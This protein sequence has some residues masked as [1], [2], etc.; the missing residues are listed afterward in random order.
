MNSRL[1][2]TIA[3]IGINHGGDYDKLLRM[4]KSSKDSGCIAVKFQYRSEK[5]FGKNQEMG[6]T[7]ITQELEKSNLKENWLNQILDY[8]KEIDIQVGFS[9]FKRDDLL[10]FDLKCGIKNIDFIKIPSPEFMNLELIKSAKETTKP[11][12]I[13]YGGGEEEEIF[14]YI[15][16]AKLDNKDCI[17][18]CITNYPVAIGNQQLGFIS[19]LKN[20]SEAQI[21]YSSHDEDWEICL[22]AI[23]HG[24]NLIERHFCESKDDIGL[25]ISTSSDPEE[26]KKLNAIVNNYHEIIGSGKRLPNQGEIVNIRSLGVGLYYNSDLKKGDVF[27]AIHTIELS[28]ATGL[29]SHDVKRYLGRPVLKNISSGD[30]VNKSDFNEGFS[31][32]K[33]SPLLSFIETNQLSLPVR[34]HD[35]EIIRDKFLCSF[36][37][38]HL[39]YKEVEQIMKDDAVVLELI[40][41]TDTISIHLPDYI[42]KDSLIDPFSKDDII[43]SA[44]NS[45]INTCV[46]LSEKIEI[47][48]NKKCIILGS[49]SVNSEIS[50]ELYYKNFKSYMTNIEEKN[51]VIIAAQWLPRKAW[52][53]GGSALLD[54]F[55]GEDDI[56]YILSNDIHICLDIAHLILSANFFNKDWYDWYKRLI[57]NCVHIHVSDAVGTDGEGVDFGTGNLGHYD[58][59]INE[60]CIKVIEVWEGHLNEGEK[61]FKAIEFLNNKIL[62]E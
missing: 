59:I 60:N 50:K 13:S 49:F 44:S 19:K 52:Y 62:D 34:L 45:I 51:G 39:S 6:S 17:F 24:A 12:Y 29:R 22:L 28:P 5:F 30:P 10:E 48:T 23:S 38:L 43:Y 21:G 26:F 3:E 33:G 32:K 18:H 61:F 31:I 16:L 41:S 8:C 46:R 53:F 57:K 4:I 1:K 56:D 20:H 25:D 35:F 42:S 40:N 11:V 37:E 2:G 9:F 36:F 58:E 7:L 27:D 55:V 54:L 15:K 14:K 47:I